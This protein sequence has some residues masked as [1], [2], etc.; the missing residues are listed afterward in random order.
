MKLLLIVVLSLLG[1]S[2]AI[3]PDGHFKYSKELTPGNFDTYINDAINA[4]QTVMVRFIASS[5]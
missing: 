3:Y 1:L 2:A 4:D 5:G